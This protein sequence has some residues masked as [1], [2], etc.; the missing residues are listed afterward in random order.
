[1]EYDAREETLELSHLFLTYTVKLKPK[2][3]YAAVSN[4]RRLQF[5]IY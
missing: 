5:F 4:I 3:I 1:M 2:Q